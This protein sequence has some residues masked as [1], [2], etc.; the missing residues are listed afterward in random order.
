MCEYSLRE[1]RAFDNTCSAIDMMEAFE[2][3]SMCNHKSFLPHGA[4]F[5]VSQNILEVGD[6]W[7]VDVSP[8]ELQNAESK[9]VADKIGARRLELSKSG[10]SRVGPGS[11][12]SGPAQLITTAGYSTTYALSTMRALLGARTLRRGDGC[13]AMPESRRNERLFGVTGSGRTKSRSMGIKLENLGK[14]YD[15]RLDTC[16]KAFVRLCAARATQLAEAECE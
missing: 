10:K 9:R 7:A 4:V 2:R 13:I 11:G 16:I 5:K 14:D 15:P 8:L 1:Q 3:G 6:I 12:A